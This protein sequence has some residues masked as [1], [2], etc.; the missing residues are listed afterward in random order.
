[1]HSHAK[2]QAWQAEPPPAAAV[3]EGTVESLRKSGGVGLVE[4]PVFVVLDS[5]GKILRKYISMS[6]PAPPKGGLMVLFMYSKASKRHGPLGR[7]WELLFGVFCL[8]AQNS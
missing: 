1:M 2:C 4:R 7:C 5:W 8:V 6:R 3:W